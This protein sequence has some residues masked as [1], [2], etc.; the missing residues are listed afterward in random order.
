M[1]R[2]FEHPRNQWTFQAPKL[3]AYVEARLIGRTLNLFG[4]VTRL[5]HTGE[6]IHNDFK[7]EL[8]RDGDWCRDACDLTQWLDS[9]KSFD[10]VIL[11][12]PWSFHQAV[13]SYGIK[14]AQKI[15]HAK[16]VIDYV[17]KPGGRV[18]TLAF[19]SNAMGVTRGYDK[20][21][22]LLVA[23]GASHNDILVVVERQTNES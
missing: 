13:I 16:D 5:A 8:L 19:N 20:E 21:E 7:P 11:D 1:S 23:Q 14:K 17:L 2:M 10:T 6:I 12:P 4:G 18:I 9:E 22:I 3:R 15:T